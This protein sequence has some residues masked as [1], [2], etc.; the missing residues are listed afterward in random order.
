MTPTLPKL[1]SPTNGSPVSPASESG[2]EYE[3]SEL[4][5]FAHATNW[6][7]YF[8]SRISKYLQG[9]VL[10]VGAGIGGT[11]KVLCHAGVN[12]WT[13]LEPDAA[14]AEKIPAHGPY[15]AE[16]KVIVGTMENIPSED[17]YDT[18]IYID[19]LEHIQD[20]RSELAHAI[21]HLAP[22]GR[23]VGLCPA[24]PKLFTPFD[25]AIGHHR[26]YTTQM[27]RD[28]TP[29]AGRCETAF[30]LDSLGMLLS[31]ANKLAL[32]QSMPTLKQ[33]RFWDKA[34]VPCSRLLDPLTGYRVGKSVVAVWSRKA[35]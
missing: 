33:I 8:R 25:A 11:T 22:G 9:R 18:I 10:E 13:C 4:E 1:H 2:Y 15:P 35:G 16:V 32:R 19:V 24:H 23:V 21:Q 6:K 26:R 17:M 28:L 31:L 12:E 14:L 20:D 29:E 5:L 34:V 7:A 30:Y 3:G 27:F